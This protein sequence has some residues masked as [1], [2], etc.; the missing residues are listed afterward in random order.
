MSNRSDSNKGKLLMALMSKIIQ[1]QRENPELIS[2][3]NYAQ[4]IQ[5]QENEDER[6][7]EISHGI[8]NIGHTEESFSEDGNNN[9]NLEFV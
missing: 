7:S 4:Q 8:S 5:V 1:K 2:S 9:I 6:K 3:A